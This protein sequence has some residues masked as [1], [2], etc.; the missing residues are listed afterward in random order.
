MKIGNIVSSIDVKISNEFNL[1]KN[2]DEIIQGLP[3]LIVGFDYVNKN[4]PDFNILDKEIEPN[5]YWTFKRTE[6]RDKFEEDL[7]WFK[8]K[9]YDDLFKQIVYIFVDPIYYRGYVMIKLLRKI[10]NI[11]NK[12]SLMYNNMIYIYGDNFIFGFDLNLLRFLKLDV[13]KIKNKIKSVS[14]VFLDDEKILIEYKNN[15]EELN[16][17]VR[18]IPYLFSINNEQKDTSSFIHIPRE[19]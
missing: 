17:R 16:D 15:I 4:Y 11:E 18:F 12:Y 7:Y 13:N 1:V 8:Q 9:V 19:S 2:M 5:I 3:T 10:I 14:T 6:K